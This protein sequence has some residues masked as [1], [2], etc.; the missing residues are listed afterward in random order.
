MLEDIRREA[1]ALL[2]EAADAPSKTNEWIEERA[3]RLVRRSAQRLANTNY[4]W[5]RMLAY[6]AAAAGLGALLCS[7]YHAL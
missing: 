2:R 6:G 7:V 1:R 5:V 3:D 4:T